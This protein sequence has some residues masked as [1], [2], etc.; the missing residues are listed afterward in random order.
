MTVESYQ[1]LRHQLS[2]LLQLFTCLHSQLSHRLLGL[3]GQDLLAKTIN[4]LQACK[5]LL[6]SAD[7]EKHLKKDILIQGN[8]FSMLP[9]IISR[10]EHHKEV[11]Q[12]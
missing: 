11:T 10:D 5:V 2:I 12:S 4:Q 1:I 8:C 6:L 3:L 7:L 9:L